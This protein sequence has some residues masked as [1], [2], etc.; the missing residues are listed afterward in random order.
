VFV[1]ENISETLT[2]SNLNVLQIRHFI[3]FLFFCR[4]GVTAPRIYSW[5]KALKQNEAKDLVVGTAGF[6]WGAQFVTV[7]CHDLE[8]NRLDGKRVTECGF[9][10]HPSALKYPD[11]INPIVLP[12]AVAASEHDP[13]MSPDQAKQTEK[14]LQ[15]KTEKTKS[16]GIEH[17]FV[18]YHGAHHGFAVSPR[19]IFVDSSD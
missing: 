15:E 13:Q 4:Y 1:R 12:Y 18:L 14:I 9:V 19:S 17:E 16:E 10:A 3:P 6:C 7:L 2:Y 5:L 11:S 8:E